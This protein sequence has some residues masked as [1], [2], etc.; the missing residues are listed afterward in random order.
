MHK[1]SFDQLL[2]TFLQKSLLN[3]IYTVAQQEG[4]DIYLVGGIVR[5]VLLRRSAEDLD[6]LVRGKAEHFAHHLAEKLDA[7]V[8]NLKAEKGTIR[9]V[10]LFEQTSLN[11]DISELSALSGKSRSPLTL[12]ST[13]TVWAQADVIKHLNSGVPI[14]DIAAGI[15]TAMAARVALLVNS[16]G[17]QND[18]C[19]TG[20]GAKN[21]GLVN[22]LEGL[23]GSS[24]K[25][26]R[27]DDPQLAGAIGAAIVAKEK[28][29]EK[30][31]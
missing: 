1:I 11:I 15:N 26:I 2:K 8:I 12:A 31:S 21:N 25:R 10:K 17:L 28:A 19:L 18:V 6:I 16:L 24:I 23:I 22:T 9:V 14:E 13:C 3:T 7:Q 4:V 30:A 27:K 29:E 20:G 5:D